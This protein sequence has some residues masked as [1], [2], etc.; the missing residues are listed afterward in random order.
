MAKTPTKRLKE[1]DKASLKKG[2][3]VFWHDPD[4]GACSR[5]GKITHIDEGEIITIDHGTEV[6]IHELSK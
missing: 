2:S 4:N 3:K 5:W 6:L 1:K